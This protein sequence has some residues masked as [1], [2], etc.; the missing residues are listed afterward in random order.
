MGEARRF[1]VAGL[2]E[3]ARRYGRRVG[4]VIGALDKTGQVKQGTATVG[5]KLGRRIEVRVNHVEEPGAGGILD[6]HGDLAAF[7]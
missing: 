4:P 3:A 6:L 1:A 2:E 5:V 7:G